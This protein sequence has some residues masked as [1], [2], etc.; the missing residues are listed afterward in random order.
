[1][2]KNNTPSYNEGGQQQQKCKTLVK[3]RYF[4]IA[5]LTVIILEAQIMD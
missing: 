5:L 1:M 2:K 4:I 3:D